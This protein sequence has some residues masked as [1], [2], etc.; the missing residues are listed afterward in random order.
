D[1]I[2]IAA[3]QKAAADG[4]KAAWQNVSNLQARA[5]STFAGTGP[6]G[7][8]FAIT[9]EVLLGKR[10]GPSSRTMTR[11]TKCQRTTPRLTN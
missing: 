4:V 8:G 1:P 7:G 11:L 10:P 6:N 9:F 5:A 2:A 3:A